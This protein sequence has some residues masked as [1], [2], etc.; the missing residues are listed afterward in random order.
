MDKMIFLIALVVFQAAEAANDNQKPIAQIE[1]P[2]K[3]SRF[4]IGEKVELKG[5][6]TDLEDGKLSGDVLVWTADG[7]YIGRGD[8]FAAVFSEGYHMIMLTVTDSKGAVGESSVFIAVGI[9]E[10]I[11]DEIKIEK[12]EPNKPETKIQE[13]LVTAK[14][15]LPYIEFVFVPPFGS[16]EDLKGRLVNGDPDQ[17]GVAV[18]IMVEA[19]WSSK[20]SLVNPV[21]KINEDGT[22]VCDITTSEDDDLAIKIAA[23]LIPAGFKPPPAYRNFYILKE[24]KDKCLASIEVTRKI[25]GKIES[26]EPVLA[27]EQPEFGKYFPLAVGNTWKYQKTVF[28]NRDAFYYSQ[29]IMLEDGPN[30]TFKKGTVLFSVGRTQGKAPEKSIESY[31]ISSFIEKEGETTW[32]IKIEG[33]M[34]RDGRYNSFLAKGN[35]NVRWRYKDNA[36]WEIIDGE[37]LETLTQNQS[38]IAVLEPGVIISSSLKQGTAPAWAIGSV[39]TGTVITPAGK[40]ENCL[41]N[42]TIIKGENLED[43]LNK[44]ASPRFSNVDDVFS[45]ANSPD[46]GKFVTLSYFKE[47]I[48]LVMESQYNHKGEIIY[49]MALID[50]RVK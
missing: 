1:S 49:E 18:Y 34:P 44:N 23:Y 15:K 14:R 12:P 36:V 38:L 27:K 47:G 26:R 25:S 46:F 6:A 20:P 40:F 2:E 22:W 35:P 13:T 31:T 41:K 43:I 37:Y 5:K 42:C 4:E 7:D 9:P 11:I 33:S 10:P 16:S 24:I 45:S 19:V 39:L 21:T 30:N 28:Q 32:D 3:G 29:Q 50:Y 8:S 48:G 17:F